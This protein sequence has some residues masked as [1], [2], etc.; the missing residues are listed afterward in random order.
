MKV[1][2]GTQGRTFICRL[3]YEADLLDSFKRLAEEGKID[4]AFFSMLGAVKKAKICNYDQKGKKYMDE[5]SL[6]G[7]LEVLSCTGN[8]A[9]F[10]GETMVH[11]HAVLSD[12]EG[13]AFGGHLLPGTTVFAGEVYMVELTGIKLEREYDP[14]TG[15]NLFK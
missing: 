14:V 10:K 13:R 3:D 7:P 9:K 4:A 11:A 1:F 12:D 8:I 6:E 5:I 15:L 2:E